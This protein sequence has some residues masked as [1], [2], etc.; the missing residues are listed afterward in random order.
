M[1]GLPAGILVS[2]RRTMTTVCTVWACHD[3]RGLPFMFLY[4]NELIVNV[5]GTA[6][7]RR[8]N[9][10]TS[11]AWLCHRYVAW[12][13]LFFILLPISDPREIRVA[14]DFA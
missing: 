5:Y 4:T 6:V 2:K 7:H 14:G 9:Q 3:A 11:I 12:M 10:Q 8:S 1:A 13:V